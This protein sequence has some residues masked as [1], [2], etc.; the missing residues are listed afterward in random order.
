MT[1]VFCFFMGF[2]CLFNG[3]E[4]TGIVLLYICFFKTFK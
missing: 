3:W 4:W 2:N 1:K